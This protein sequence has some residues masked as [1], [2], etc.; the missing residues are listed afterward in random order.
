MKKLTLMYMLMTI[1]VRKDTARMWTRICLIPKAHTFTL[2]LEAGLSK[3][4]SA[5]TRSRQVTGGAFTY[6]AGQ[7][8]GTCLKPVFT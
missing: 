6:N 4:H 3:L 1:P 7:G 2:S 5:H 8:L